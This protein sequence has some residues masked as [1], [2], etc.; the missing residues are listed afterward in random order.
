MTQ[1]KVTSDLVSGKKLGDLVSDNDLAG[2]NI[3]A[4]LEAGHIA[5]LG[6]KNKKSDHVKDEE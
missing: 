6:S 4:L 2:A 1:Y 5:E 3:S